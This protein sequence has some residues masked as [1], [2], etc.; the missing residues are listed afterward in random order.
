M[1]PPGPLPSIGK[2][3]CLGPQLVP[4]PGHPAL[5]GPAVEGGHVTRTI[6][7]SWHH[8]RGPPPRGQ[9]DPL[10]VHNREVEYLRKTHRSGPSSCIERHPVSLNAQS[11]DPAG[12]VSLGAYC[13]LV[14]WAPAILGSLLFCRLVS[15]LRSCSPRAPLALGQAPAHPANPSS[16][17]SMLAA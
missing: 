8:P 10:K 1:S 7:S 17:P 6:V 12:L 16:C 13:P 2:H 14:L 4:G 15:A 3:A 5:P 11:A 9:K